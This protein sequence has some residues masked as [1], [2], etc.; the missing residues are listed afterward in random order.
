MINKKYLPSKTFVRAL[1]I[2]I[3][4]VIVA[5]VSN[6]WK[7]SNINFN[8]NVAFNLNASNTWIANAVD[9]DKDGLP[10]WQEVL[11]GTDPKKADTDG[12]GAS[13][14]EET[15]LN[16]DPL[17]TNTAGKDKEPN[18]MIEESI[19]AYDKKITEEYQKLSATEKMARDLMSNIVASQPTSGNMDQATVNSLVTR[20][21]QDIPDKSFTGTTKISDLNIIKIDVKTLG[22]DLTT[23]ANAYIKET[24]VLRKTLGKDLK[25][26]SDYLSET[27]SNPIDKEKMNAVIAVYEEV[28]NNLK[29]MPLPAV[30]GSPGAT[31]HLIVINDIEKLIAIDKDILDSNGDNV[32]VF[33]DLAVYNETA[34]DLVLALDI[35][36]M[37]LKIQR[38]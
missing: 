4:I 33:S 18:D 29:K 37:T 7:P 8:N 5:I 26:V 16:R 10:D 38:I 2:A 19:I 22:K 32:V 6:Y 31:Y 11:M 1:L 12:D 3:F 20:S 14:G 30:V 24:E 21:I 15:V 35:I 13:D 27:N 36:D 9:T 34:D 28:A 25:I 23:Y 17:K